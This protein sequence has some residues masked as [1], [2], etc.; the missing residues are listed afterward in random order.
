MKLFNTLRFKHSNNTMEIYNRVVV[1]GHNY[2]E[3]LIILPDASTLTDV[4]DETEFHYNINSY[5]NSTEVMLIQA[6]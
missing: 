2:Y 4:L 6:L 1:Q 5:V 3:Q